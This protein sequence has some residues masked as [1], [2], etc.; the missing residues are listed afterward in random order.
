MWHKHI[1]YCSICSIMSA[2][3]HINW[4]DF[5]NSE[6]SICLDTRIFKNRLT[7]YS[8]MWLGIIRAWQNKDL[9]N[10]L[11][12]YDH[13][14]APAGSIPSFAARGD[15]LDYSRLNN[16]FLWLSCDEQGVDG[17][18]RTNTIVSV[19]HPAAEPAG[20]YKA[21]LCF[22]KSSKEE[23]SS[24]N[25]GPAFEIKPGVDKSFFQPAGPEAILQFHNDYGLDRPYFVVCSERDAQTDWGLL[26][27]IFSGVVSP[28]AFKLVLIGETVELT[29]LS[30]S[31]EIIQGSF[32]ER[33]LAAL[34]SGALGMLHLPQEQNF[35]LAVLEALSCSCPV[36]SRENKVSKEL[37]GDAAIYF[38]TAVEAV[39]AICN[40]LA[41]DIQR[42][43]TERA[44]ECSRQYDCRD[45]ALSLAAL[46][47]NQFSDRISSR[48]SWE[49]DACE[50]SALKN[51]ESLQDSVLTKAPVFIVGTGRSGTNIVERVACE[52]PSLLR[53]GEFN[54]F[55]EQGG[56]FDWIRGYTT[57]DKFKSI[58]LD[59]I[60]LR[61]NAIKKRIAESLSEDAFSYQGEQLR[62]LVEKSIETGASRQVSAIQIVE[63]VIAPLMQHFGCTRW[64]DKTP[65]NCYVA[66]LLRGLYPKMHV[67][68]AIRDPRDVFSSILTKKWGPR[69]SEEFVSWYNKIMLAA[70]EIEKKLASEQYFVV[71]LENLVRN[72]VNIS[73]Q[74]LSFLECDN[75]DQV[76]DRAAGIIDPS[77]ANI[78]RW[79]EQ[80]SRAQAE[81]VSDGCRELY[82]IWLNR[83]TQG[84]NFF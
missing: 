29:R 57:T 3:A 48:I 4:R 65:H 50:D 18:D 13:G 5:P 37:A 78:G 81:Y 32:T 7:S 79:K 11:F 84:T 52:H 61:M 23:I 69:T 30:E 82:Q 67:I 38:S 75:V 19:L 59:R 33:E 53:L 44:Y 56:I 49:S 15:A 9:P 27:E 54:F 12:I 35:S 45:T 72:R 42:G 74:I 76:A 55:F 58:M 26:E 41:A 71:S 8:R 39:P 68:H 16:K 34:Y 10:G 24:R 36:I 73:R 1:I 77:S 31:I 47:D 6:V 66:D 20:D 28:Y 83:E 64:C 62:S 2:P 60:P 22:S 25:T 14:S 70:W 80:L 46:F 51:I 17:I 63:G 21:V 43:L 40:L